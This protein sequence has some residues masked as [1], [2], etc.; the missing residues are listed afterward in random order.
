MSE[1][2][3]A[4]G[5][6]LGALYAEINRLTAENEAL[7]EEVERLREGEKQQNFTRIKIEGNALSPQFVSNLFRGYA[8][9]LRQQAKE[10]QK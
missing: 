5:N 2:A 6:T 7:R 3:K 9:Q 10:P 4:A 1:L 8:N